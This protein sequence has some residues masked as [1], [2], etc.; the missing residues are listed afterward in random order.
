MKWDFVVFGKPYGK[1][2]MRPMRKGAFTSMYQPKENEDYMAQTRYAFLQKYPE[3][4]KSDWIPTTKGLAVCLSAYWPIPKG[5]SK[6][7]RE[8]MLSGEIRPTTKPDC[9]NISKAICDAV[10][11]GLIAHDDSQVQTLIVEKRFAE[12]ARVEITISEREETK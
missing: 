4:G 11:N 9:D 3:V 12:V 7:K 6:K 8:K 1:K 5:T 2:N 10:V